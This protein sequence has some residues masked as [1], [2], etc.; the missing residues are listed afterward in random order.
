MNFN[1]MSIFVIGFSISFLAFLFIIPL[2]RKLNIGQF[3]REEGPSWHKSKEGTPT[4]GGIVFLLIP[5]LFLPFIKNKLFLIIYLSILFNG[6]IGILDDSLSVL[7]KESEGLSVRNRLLLQTA[8]SVILYF[9]M[10]PFLSNYIVIGRFVLNVSPLVYFLFFIFLAV[11]TTN[12]FNLTDGID[13]LLATDSIAML[14]F[15]F[16]GGIYFAKVFNLHLLGSN[17]MLILML[18]AVVAYLWFNSPRASIFMGDTGSLSLG[19]IVFAVAVVSKMEILLAFIAII[20]V[21]EA[22]SVFMQ[23]SYFKI[24]HGRRIFKMAPIHHH[25]EKSGWSESKIVFRFLIITIISS[26]L[27]F[28]LFGIGRFR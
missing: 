10:K 11:G 2:F 6:L 20:P 4:A 1:Y 23:V 15:L 26:A 16:F 7:R 24:T 22:I 8:V 5:V 14:V 21:I 18:S 17:L 3:I 19:G 9:I 28:L 25:F 13:G 27:G 12:A